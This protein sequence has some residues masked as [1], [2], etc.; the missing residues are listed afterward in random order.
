MSFSFWIVAGCMLLVALIFI[1][2][3]L[4]RSRL[5]GARA[6]MV[7][8]IALT[9]S[10]PALA[11]LLYAALG[12]SRWEESGDLPSVEAMI[13]ALEA[14]L[15]NE[16]RNLDGWLM[17]GRSYVVL[18][19]FVDAARAYGRAYELSD[20]QDVEVITSYAEALA[21]SDSTAL[22]GSAG[23]LFAA[24]LAIAPND[25][26]ALWYGG[27]SAYA[28]GELQTARERW[29]R[30][31]ELAP[32]AAVDE[33]LVERLDEIDQRLGVTAALEAAAASGADSRPDAGGLKLHISLDPAL[34]AR[35]EPGDVLFVIARETSAE[36]GPPVAVVRRSASEL[37][38]SVRLTDA[39]AM[40]PGRALSDFAE[41]Q[42]VARISLGGQ[43]LPASGDLFGEADY[44]SGQAEPVELSIDRVVP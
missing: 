27:L 37:P 22:E 40:L 36:G 28:R 17:L 33:L 2:V 11:L 23:E 10:V 21:L 24:A 25:P 42:L 16:P 5:P 26:K 8:G 20:G 34:A 39:D 9:I 6:R 13:G 44:R 18:Q 29:S 7:T 14:R 4:W 38:L 32:P 41:L 15:A 31:R 1:L 30:L 19:R 3:P 35:V 43:A 12:T